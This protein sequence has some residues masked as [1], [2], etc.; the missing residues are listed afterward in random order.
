MG[1]SQGR[2]RSD[3]GAGRAAQKRRKVRFESRYSSREKTLG[4]LDMS[5][6]GPEPGCISRPWYAFSWV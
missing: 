2:M 1:V 5:C 4:Y 3:R 6:G